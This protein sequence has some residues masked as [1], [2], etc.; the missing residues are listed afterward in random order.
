MEHRTAL[1][2]DFITLA[3]WLA[4]EFSNRTQAID[5]PRD[6]AHIHVFFRPLP[7][8]FF[9]GIG[10]Y[11][12]QAYDYD[13]WTP[14]R[15]GIHH[16]VI[17]NN[18]IYIKNFGLKNAP[19]YAGSGRE[20]SIL[21]TIKPSDIQERCGCAMVFHREG[22]QFLGQVEPGRQCLIPKEGRQTYLVS[23]VEMTESTWVSRDRGY[24]VGTDEQI[25]GSEVGVF[26]FEKQQSF[27]H[28]LPLQDLLESHVYT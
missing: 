15:Q 3:Q 18:Q 9:Q 4:S 22:T 11:S 17:Q 5:Q 23:E 19:R 14:Y 20:L 2:D 27:A 8:E 26:Q 12:E 16:L 6:F 1:M 13:L 21:N 24:D 25:W 10:F 28:E 7:F